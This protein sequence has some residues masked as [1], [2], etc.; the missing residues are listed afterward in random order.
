MLEI[1]D[2]LKLIKKKGFSNTLHVLATF[3]NYKADKHV[4]YDELNKISYYNSFIR[5]KDELLERG[6][7]QLKTYG[8]TRYII[9][10]EKGIEIYDKLTEI[11]KLVMIK[12][13]G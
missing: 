8:S 2:L 13:K 9:L 11:N 7:I 4:F 12:T 6:L 5:I 1:E 10:T 3:E